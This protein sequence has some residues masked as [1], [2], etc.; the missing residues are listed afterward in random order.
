MFELLGICL[1]LAALLTFNALAAT[2]ASALWSAIRVRAED[3]P[4]AARARLLFALRVFPAII[5]VFCVGALLLP[6]YIAHEPRPAVEPVSLK[7]GVLAAISAAGLL[8]A[9][10]RGVAAWVA[11]HRLI[12][13]WL[14]VAEP[15]SFDQIPAY[16]LR[17]QFPVIAVVG[18]IRPKLFIADQLFQSLTCEEMAAAIAHESGHLAARDNLK[19]AALR[20]CRDALAIFPGGASLDRAWA[21]A[22][23][24]AAD[25]HAARGG[26]AVALNLAPT[27]VKIARLV[28]QGVKPAMPADASLIVYDADGIA[29]RVRRLMRM[30]TL[31]DASHRG[32]VFNSKAWPWACFAAILILAIL[33]TT[34]PSALRATHDVIEIVVSK[35]Q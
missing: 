29:Q 27:L 22:S 7:L 24:A 18:A 25:E 30:A 28:P 12:K 20:V 16:R 4:A 32:R 35:L 15:I 8:L 14:R 31:G 11:T 26:R 19:L 23:E 5:A 2:L 10:W 13:N 3:W 1:A 17:H 9:L 34:S 6:A 33:S 21:E